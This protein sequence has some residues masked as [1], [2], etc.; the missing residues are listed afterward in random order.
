MH[1][2]GQMITGHVFSDGARHKYHYWPEASR[3][4]WGFAHIEDHRILLYVYGALPGPIQTSPM[5]ELYAVV[6]IL[7]SA[8]LPPA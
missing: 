8:M 4:G 7:R 2:D 5:A 3:A 1:G 6:Q